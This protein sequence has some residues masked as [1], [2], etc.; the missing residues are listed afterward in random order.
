M[1]IRDRNLAIPAITPVLFQV[2]VTLI[3]FPIG[4]VILTTVNMAFNR[5]RVSS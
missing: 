1:C 3:L 4:Y 5:I 2:G